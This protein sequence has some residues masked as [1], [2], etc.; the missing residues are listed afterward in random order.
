MKDIEINIKNDL[1]NMNDISS[2]KSSKISYYCSECQSVIEIVKLD[3]EI[4]EFKCNNNHNIKISIKEYLDKIKE[5]N[6]KMPLNE[7]V[8]LNNS[9]CD[10][11]KEKYLSYCFECN[12]HL[13]EKC[14]ITGDHSYHYKINIIEI[15]PNDEI[16]LRI[17]NLIKNNKKKIKNLNKN[18]KVVESKIN[19]I[20]KE[21]INKIKDMKN[22]NKKKNKNNKKEELKENNDKYILEIEELKREYNTVF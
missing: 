17:Q 12:M 10:K 14:L 6:N 20:L 16:L 7:D 5:S 22:K 13:C 1:N 18:K 19:D 8:Y 15:K 2:F 21:N 4:I 3:E 9:I 11:H